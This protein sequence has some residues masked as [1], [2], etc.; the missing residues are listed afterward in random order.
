MPDTETPEAGEQLTAS[1]WHKTS[2]DEEAP[3]TDAVEQATPVRVDDDSTE[4]PLPFDVDEADAVD[5]T[6]AIPGDDDDYR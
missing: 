5:Q 3:E 6:R 4:D 1:S 2:T